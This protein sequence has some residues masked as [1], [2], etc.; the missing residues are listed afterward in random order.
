M[1]KGDFPIFCCCKFGKL[2]IWKKKKNFQRILVNLLSP[3][4]Y[5]F[6]PLAHWPFKEHSKFNMKFTRHA[7]SSFPIL[8]LFGG[9]EGIIKQILYWIHQKLY[10]IR[11]FTVHLFVFFVFCFKKDFIV[12]KSQAKKKTMCKGMGPSAEN[13]FGQ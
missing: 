10:L 4:N 2:Q 1:T 13:I 8:Y 12:T 5:C 3:T 11:I 7:I 6:Q 9:I